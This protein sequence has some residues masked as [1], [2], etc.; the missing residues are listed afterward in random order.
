MRR[1][2]DFSDID[3]KSLFRDN[4][5]HSEYTI[6][7]DIPWVRILVCLR[8]LMSDKPLGKIYEAMIH[9]FTDMQLVELAASLYFA[10]EKREGL[11]YVEIEY[12]TYQNIRSL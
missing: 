12:V 6:Q 5:L 2:K 7:T 1:S 9:G 8:F 11:F 3:I 4:W 10:K